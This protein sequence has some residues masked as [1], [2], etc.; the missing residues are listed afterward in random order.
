MDVV[1]VGVE[2]Q[3]DE[4]AVD[5]MTGDLE[6][7]MNRMAQSLT[8]NYVVTLLTKGV[9]A[10][11]LIAIL[12]MLFKCTRLLSTLILTTPVATVT[13]QDMDRKRK[14]TQ[15]AMLPFGMNQPVC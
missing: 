8:C 3:T 7:T 6:M 9:A 10:G 4:E 13:I 15:Q 12:N 14:C 1:G 2:D 5:L 11:A